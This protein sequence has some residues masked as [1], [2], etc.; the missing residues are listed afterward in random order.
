MTRNSDEA[1]YK[2]TFWDR[3]AY[4][5]EVLRGHSPTFLEMLEGHFQYCDGD[6]D[7]IDIDLAG[8]AWDGCTRKFW[9]GFQ[10]PAINIEETPKSVQGV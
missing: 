1:P 3:V 10:N 4:A 8:S 7:C 2:A 6:S 5:V 9:A